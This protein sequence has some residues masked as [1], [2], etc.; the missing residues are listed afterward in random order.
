MKVIILFPCKQVWPQETVIMPEGPR[1]GD[2]IYNVLCRRVVV[3]T[4]RCWIKDTND[5]FILNVE[6]K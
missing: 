6:V 1:V 3:V 4:K 2:C 5:E